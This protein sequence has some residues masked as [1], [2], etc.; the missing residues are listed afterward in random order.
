MTNQSSKSISIHPNVD[1]G[2]N[3]TDKNFK[4]GTLQYKCDKDKVTLLI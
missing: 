1:N 4:G 2:I 3:P